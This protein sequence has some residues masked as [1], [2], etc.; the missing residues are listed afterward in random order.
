MKFSPTTL[1]MFLCGQNFVKAFAFSGSR[2]MLAASRAG[3]RVLLSSAATEEAAAAAEAEAVLAA[4]GFV[5][6]TEY[7]KQLVVENAGVNKG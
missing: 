4:I 3:S 6:H 1:I 2:P 7:Q 5:L